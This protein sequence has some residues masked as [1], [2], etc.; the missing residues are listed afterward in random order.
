MCIGL[1]YVAYLSSFC[2]D[3]IERNALNSSGGV[4]TQ[5]DGQWCQ[6]WPTYM[7]RQDPWRTHDLWMEYTKDMAYSDFGGNIK[8]IWQTVTEEEL[9]LRH[10]KNVSWHFCSSLLLTLAEAEPWKSLLGSTTIADLCLLFHLYWTRLLI[11]SW[12]VELLTYEPF[13]DTQMGAASKNLSKQVH[14][15]HILSL[16]SGELKGRLKH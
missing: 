6:L 11:Y 3:S 9:G 15:L 12:S 7:L 16:L 10:R 14:F 5:A 4:W 2:L 8:G 1:P 13:P